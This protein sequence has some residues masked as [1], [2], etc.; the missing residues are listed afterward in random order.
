MVLQLLLLWAL[1]LLLL[2]QLLWVLVGVCSC[3][4]RPFCCCCP[5]CRRCMRLSWCDGC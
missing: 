1:H 5:R 3:D 2:L 4:R